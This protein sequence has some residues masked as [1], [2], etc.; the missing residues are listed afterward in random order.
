MK[1]SLI[2]PLIY[3]YIN[4]TR[5]PSLSFFVYLSISLNLSFLLSSLFFFFFLFSLRSN[6]L[7][8]LTC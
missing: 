1:K 3:K 5:S 4:I 8:P 7:Q 6:Q 2:K